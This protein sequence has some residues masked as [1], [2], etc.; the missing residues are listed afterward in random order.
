MN[1]TARSGM[2]FAFCCMWA[3]A[4]RTVDQLALF[5]LLPGHERRGGPVGL[6]R[7]LRGP[8]K[9]GC[10]GGG[11]GHLRTPER[12]VLAAPKVPASWSRPV[13]PVHAWAPVVHGD[14]T[15]GS[16]GRVDARA[17]WPSGG[18]GQL[19]EWWT[20]PTGRVDARVDWPSGGRG[21]TG[22]RP[23]L[24]TLPGVGGR[25]AGAVS[26]PGHA[27]SGARVGEG[28]NWSRVDDGVNW[29]TTIPSCPSRR[30]GGAWGGV[31]SHHDLG[32]SSASWPRPL[33][34]EGRP[35]QPSTPFLFLHHG[36]SPVDP[37]PSASWPLPVGQLTP[38]LGQLTPPSP[39]L[40]GTSQGVKGAAGPSKG[41]GTKVWCV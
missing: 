19:V 8:Q 36:Q 20:G 34:G 16:T 1:C 41:P 33:E 22:R 17:N 12:E 14:G 40:Q 26:A 24:P 30:P 15:T 5:P 3:W 32:G 27:W 23:S 28:V 11:G 29:P 21:Q 25:L 38:P 13:G 2:G 10:W 37:P 9:V 7:S 6:R 4:V 35:Y 18:R 31:P 39:L